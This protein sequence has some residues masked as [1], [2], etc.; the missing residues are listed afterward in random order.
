[1][2]KPGTK[3]KTILQKDYDKLYEIEQTLK[4]MH[5]EWVM[6]GK[7]YTSEVRRIS[8]IINKINELRMMR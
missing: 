7:T 4:D 2:R 5:F 1:M 8:T 6:R 3:T